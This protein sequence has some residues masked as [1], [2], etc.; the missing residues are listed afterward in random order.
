[1]CWNVN[2]QEINFHSKKTAAQHNL[3]PEKSKSTIVQKQKNLLIKSGDTQVGSVKQENNWFKDK[4]SY[5]FIS[6]EP[7]FVSSADT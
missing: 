7:N 5:D 4:Q 6:L 2:S 1:M 3:L